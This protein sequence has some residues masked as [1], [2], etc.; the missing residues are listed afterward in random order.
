M[1]A[2][3]YNIIAPD[4]GMI[5]SWKNYIKAAQTSIKVGKLMGDI[6]NGLSLKTGLEASKVIR[7]HHKIKWI[8]SKYP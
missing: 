2:G 5:I 1:Q 4:Y 3:D 8:P 6:L 7:R